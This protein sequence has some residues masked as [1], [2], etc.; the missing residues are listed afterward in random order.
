[1]QDAR[2]QDDPVKQT[3]KRGNITFATGGPNTR[4][5]QVFINY[6]DNGRLDMGFAPFGPVVS[7]MKTVD[8]L[9]GEYGEG[10]PGGMGPTSPACRA[11]A[12][13]T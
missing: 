10:A 1:M 11:R 4:T 7:G 6:N 3:N 2:I 8:A 12:T 13:P 9:N 5:S